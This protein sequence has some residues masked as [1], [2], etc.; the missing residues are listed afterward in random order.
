[1][2]VVQVRAFEL[3]PQLPH[4]LRRPRLD[5]RVL[6]RAGQHIGVHLSEIPRMAAQDDGQSLGRY[7]EVEPLDV[8]QRI[9]RVSGLRVDQREELVVELD[10]PV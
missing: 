6:A 2:T 1:M 3:S 4:V 10:P 7:L 8:I 5:D 9:E